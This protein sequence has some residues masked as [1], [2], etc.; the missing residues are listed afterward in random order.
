MAKY[1]YGSDPDESPPP[2]V[3]TIPSLK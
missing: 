2:V 3:E 1:G